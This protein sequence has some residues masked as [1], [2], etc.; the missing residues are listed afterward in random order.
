MHEEWVSGLALSRTPSKRGN[1]P[2]DETEFMDWLNV[3][4]GS[5]WVCWSLLI[6]LQEGH[7]N[8]KIYIVEKSK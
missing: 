4:T 8:Y 7:H 5:Q 3:Q 2:A 6:G 1:H